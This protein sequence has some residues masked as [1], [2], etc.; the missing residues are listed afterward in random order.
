[1]R[2]VNCFCQLHVLFYTIPKAFTDNLAPEHELQ[3]Y[4]VIKCPTLLPIVVTL[5]GG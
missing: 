3:C 4:G 5:P 2:E 1:M